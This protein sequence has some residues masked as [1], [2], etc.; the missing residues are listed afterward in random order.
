MSET[1][2]MPEKV[3]EE[4]LKLL[5]IDPRSM[6]ISAVIAAVGGGSRA[7]VAPILKQIRNEHDAF[8]AAGTAVPAELRARADALVTSLFSEARAEASRLFEDRSARFDGLMHALEVDV[9]DGVAL[10]GEATGQIA[11]LQSKLDDANKKNADLEARSVALASANAELEAS[12][13][14][15]KLELE[16]AEEKITAQNRRLDANQTM[17]ERLGRIEKSLKITTSA[18]A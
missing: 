3:R 1:I 16:R 7:T 5:A 8:R 2:A 12:A 13:H 14:A 11:L 15:L 9:A 6:T 17:A 10:L 18:T 4:A